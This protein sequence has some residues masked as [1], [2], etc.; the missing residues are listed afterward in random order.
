MAT[1][2]K[3][4]NKEIESVVVDWPVKWKVLVSAEEVLDA[5]AGPPLNAPVDQK[6]VHDSDWESREASSRTPINLEAKMKYE[7]TCMKRR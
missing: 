6:I 5:E 4:T 1:H 7:E 2:Y 3:L